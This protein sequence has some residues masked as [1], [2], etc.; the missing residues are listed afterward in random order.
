VAIGTL[1]LEG[2]LPLTLGANIGTTLT[3]V[4]AALVGDSSLGFQLAMV[5]VFYNIFGVLMFYPIPK[6]RALPIG[7]ARKLGDLA[8]TY[9][10]FPIF[11]IFMLFLVYP[12]FFLAISIGFES[13]GGGIAGALIGLLFFMAAHI[14]FFIWYERRGGKETLIRMFGANW[15]DDEDHAKVA[16]SNPM[17][18]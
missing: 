14:A 3:G 5:H 9:K 10:A 1:T 18:A 2:M 11:Y 8:A 16:A 4:L 17:S 15:G 7:A 13:G 12:G 6:I